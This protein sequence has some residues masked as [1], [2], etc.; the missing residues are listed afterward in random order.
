[1]LAR[2]CRAAITGLGVVTPIGVGQ[3]DLWT[4]LTAGRCGIRRISA[5]DP[6]GFPSQ[7]AGEVDGYD[8]R[9]YLEKKD[10][11]LLRVLSRPVQ[12]SLGA[13][14]QAFESAQIDRNTLDPARLSIKV[15]TNFLPSELD[16]VA[17]LNLACARVC[18]D[19]SKP[20]AIDFDAV[21]E[22]GLASM[23]PLWMLKYL[24]NM[25]GCHLS[26]LHNSQGPLNTLI[27]GDVAGAVSVI[28][29]VRTIQC[30]RADL[31]L[32]GGAESKLNPVSL[33]RL[34]GYSGLSRQNADPHG[35]CRPFDRRRTGPVIGEGAGLLC[36]EDLDRAEKRDAPVLAEIVGI[37]STTYRDVSQAVAASLRMALRDANLSPSDLGHVNAHALG[38]PELDRAEAKG[39][40]AVVGQN[41]PVWAQKGQFGNLGAASGVIELAA[42]IM[43]V[44]R[45]VLPGT[46]NFTERDPGCEILVSPGSAPLSNPWF[47][48]VCYTEW[49]QCAAIVCRVL[50]PAPGGAA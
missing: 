17:E 39:L 29:A 32:T 23:E 50:Q 19:P 35:A 5:F 3:T 14:I 30:G 37:G 10:R 21:G 48:K 47:A 28:E 36:I 9:L 27:T 49:G 4:G 42:S 31:V 22:R 24:P 38:S 46:Y 1:M 26:I 15:G 13:A 25:L 45:G 11:K 33:T 16:E 6:S 41:V 7:I 8:A 43:A 12:L 2:L 34:C 18:A 44:Q 40:H 20:A